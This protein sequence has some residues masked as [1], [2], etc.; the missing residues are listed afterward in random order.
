MWLTFQHYLP[1]Q[2]KCFDYFLKYLLLWKRKFI[3]KTTIKIPPR[4]SPNVSNHLIFKS[5]NILHAELKP[6][7]YH[8]AKVVLMQTIFHFKCYISN[9]LHD[10]QN[11]KTKMLFKYLIEVELSI[12]GYLRIFCC[13]FLIE[14]YYFSH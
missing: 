5:K 8:L 13:L 7:I 3:A 12:I 14:L 4:P 2:K 11:W 9:K 10:V 6:E 1:T